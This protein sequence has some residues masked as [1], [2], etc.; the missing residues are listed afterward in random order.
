MNKYGTCRYYTGCGDWDLCCTI[1]HPTPKE[2]ERG[3]LFTFGHLCYKDTDAC[4]T[5][6]SKGE[7][8]DVNENCASR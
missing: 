3:I 5:Y 2:K 4:D 1:Q 8:T 7:E 6:D